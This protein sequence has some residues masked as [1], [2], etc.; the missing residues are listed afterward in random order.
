MANHAK[1]YPSR[2]FIRLG[3]FFLVGATLL[4]LQRISPYRLS[5]ALEQLP[6]QTVQ[7]SIQPVELTISS[8]RLDV[9]I[10]PTTI[11]NGIWHAKSDS[12]A[13]L[14][15]SPIPGDTGNSIVYGHNWPNLLGDL[16]KVK[17]ND[18]ISVKFSNGEKRTFIVEY[19]SVV[20]PD[21]THILFPSSDRRLTIYTCTGFL[22]TKR[23]VAVALLKEE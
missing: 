13:Y 17:P 19:T 3:L 8:I 7:S 6:E 4:S 11:D 16:P 12:A 14:A 22:D 9:P 20:T 15:S 1:H 2:F 21:Q 18:E 5:F 10:T 23:F